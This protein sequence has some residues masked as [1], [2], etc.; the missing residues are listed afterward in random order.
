MG[1]RSHP[2]SPLSLRPPQSRMQFPN[3][4]DS[5]TR[6]DKNKQGTQGELHAK[7]LSCTTV[8]GRP[9]HPPYQKS[10]VIP[11]GPHSSTAQKPRNINDPISKPETSSR[12]LRAKLLGGTRVAPPGGRREAC[13]AWPRCRWAAAGPGRAS[14]ST[15]PSRQARVWRSRGRAAAHRHTQRPGPTSSARAPARHSKR[16]RHQPTPCASA[17]THP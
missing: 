11:P 6:I 10:H 2:C 12:E 5:S 3:R 4:S 15:T 1:L 17:L 13:G 9:R 7:L 16:G 8:P 14:R